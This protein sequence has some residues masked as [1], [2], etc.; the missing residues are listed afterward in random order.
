MEDAA[1]RLVRE[2][3]KIVVAMAEG[4][5]ELQAWINVLQLLL[6]EAKGVP[7]SEHKYFLQQMGPHQA[8]RLASIP[9]YEGLEQVRALMAFLE[10]G[11]DPKK[12]YS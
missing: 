6:L 10:S 11:H 7:E 2:L 3:A 5:R 8:K 1:L 9:P 4:Q 12:P